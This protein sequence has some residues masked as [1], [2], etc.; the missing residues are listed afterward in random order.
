LLLVLG[1][2]GWV[3]GLVQVL[4]VYPT[5]PD[6]PDRT[7]WADFAIYNALLAY[8]VTAGYGQWRWSRELKA[9]G[10]RREEKG[11]PG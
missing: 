7:G 3:S 5:T 9:A 2:I 8:F 10:P 11:L 4:G 1:S 6:R